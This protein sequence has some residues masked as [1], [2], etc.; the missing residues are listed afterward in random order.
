MAEEISKSIA[1]MVAEEPVEII[2]GASG[3]RF[4]RWR[5]EV[6]IGSYVYSSD[7]A[8]TKNGAKKIAVQRGQHLHDR[9]NSLGHR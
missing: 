4:R 7:L 2:V 9:M 1:A 5:I 6:S 8:F 3:L